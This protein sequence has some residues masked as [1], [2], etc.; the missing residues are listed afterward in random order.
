MNP[1]VAREQLSGSGRRHAHAP[2]RRV[3]ISE[4]LKKRLRRTRRLEVLRSYC[5][6]IGEPNPRQKPCQEVG[7]FANP[8]CIR[9]NCTMYWGGILDRQMHRGLVHALDRYY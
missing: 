2:A 9:S 8:A 3:R 5:E 1:A 7:D 6:N 4:S